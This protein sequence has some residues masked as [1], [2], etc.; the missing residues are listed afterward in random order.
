V[1]WL[2][3]YSNALADVQMR[4]G[5][6]DEGRRLPEQSLAKLQALQSSTPGLPSLADL[7][8]QT[9]GSLANAGR[10]GR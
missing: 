8:S 10:K 5:R 7:I 1:L 6:E 3:A 9:Q 4:Q 2:V